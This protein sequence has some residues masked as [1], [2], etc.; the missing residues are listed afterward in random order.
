[1][2]GQLTSDAPPDDLGA[3]G[4]PPQCA[5]EKEQPPSTWTRLK[6]KTIC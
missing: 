1:V 4:A 3:P 6:N 5:K 2:A